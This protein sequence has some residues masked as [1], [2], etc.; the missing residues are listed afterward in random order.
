MTTQPQDT[1]IPALRYPWL[2]AAY[3]PILA[4]TTREATF[5]RALLAQTRIRSGQR[6]LDLGC[7]TGTLTIGLKQTAADAL[8]VGLDGDAAV[9]DQARTKA[10]RFGVAV[11]FN[12]GLSYALP[13]ASESFDKVVSS[14]FFHHLTLANKRRTFAEIERLLKPSGELHV[15][16]WGP[17]QNALMR[18]AFLGVQI[19]DGFTTTN[20]NVR[21]LI[22]TLMRDSGLED[23]HL[24]AEYA[25]LFGTLSLY[26][27][28]KR[29]P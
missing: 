15:A 22:P 6:V 5:K 10:Q 17:P 7:G 1:Y 20:D 2:T 18:V 25:T 16:D 24:T 26:Q 12:R 23:I 21:G 4:W 27:G 9:L 29:I 13:Y 14:L 28:T 3:D 11:E 8:V 19:L